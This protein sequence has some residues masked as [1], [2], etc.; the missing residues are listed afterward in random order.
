ME[1]VSVVP[2]L[3][4]MSLRLRVRVFF[5]LML[6]YDQGLAFSYYGTV[7]SVSYHT[8][9]LVREDKETFKTRERRRLTAE[10]LARVE[11][12]GNAALSLPYYLDFDVPAYLLRIT[13]RST[14]GSPPF[15]L[16]YSSF[17]LYSIAH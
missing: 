11:W 4:E 7:R 9:S 16:L 6:E 5:G 17:I 15:F 8:T 14:F 1:M 10:S 12:Q 2:C 13:N 3:V